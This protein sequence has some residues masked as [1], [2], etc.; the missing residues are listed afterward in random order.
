M[1]IK[2][3]TLLFKCKRPLLLL[4]T[5]AAFIYLALVYFS[6]QTTSITTHKIWTYWAYITSDMD[7]G[8]LMIYQPL[9]VDCTSC[10]WCNP[11][12][13]CWPC[14]VDRRMVLL[15]GTILSLLCTSYLYMNL[16]LDIW[17]LQKRCSS[18]TL[19]ISAYIATL[20]TTITHV[21]RLLTLSV[22]N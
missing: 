14:G 12:W 8:G 6:Q 22:P 20:D 9:L 18:E 11:C 15:A 1:W 5:T 13:W 21:M 16:T 4:L 17:E 2:C 3:N 7:R 10:L 19:Y